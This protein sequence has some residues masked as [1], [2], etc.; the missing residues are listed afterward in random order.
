MSRTV[1][2]PLPPCS[3]SRR[4]LWPAEQ[5]KPV[6][7]ELMAYIRSVPAK[8]RTSD[9]PLESLQSCDALT[10]LL[11]AEDAR[12]ARKELSEIG[13]RVLR[14]GTLV[15]QMLYDRERLVVQAGKPVE[16]VFE[17]S[18]TMPHNWVLVVAP[19]RWKRLACCPRK[20]ARTRRP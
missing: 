1:L 19:E 20:L 5:A 13:V 15:E 17:N 4:E 10:A 6:L 16:L 7:D 8:D 12:K 11:P 2:Q 18:D 9:T 14:L 3:V